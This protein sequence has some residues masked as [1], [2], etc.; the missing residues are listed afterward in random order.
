LGRLW[1]TGEHIA[2]LTLGFAKSVP[3]DRIASLFSVFS[4]SRQHLPQ[5]NLSKDA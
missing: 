1:R 2:F 5:L 3:K 4:G